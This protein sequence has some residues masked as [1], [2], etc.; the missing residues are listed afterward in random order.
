MKVVVTGGTGFLGWHLV[1]RLLRDGHDVTFTGRQLKASAPLGSCFAKVNLTDKQG[2]NKVMQAAEW[3]FHSA[4]LS[5]PWGDKQDFFEANVMG[6]Q[7]VVD[8]C[9]VNNVQRLIHVSTPSLYVNGQDCMMVKEDDPL[10]KQAINLY[11]HSKR[12]AEDIIKR[13]STKLAVI[14][15]RPRAIFGPGDNAIFPRFIAALQAGRLPIIG[16]GDNVADL[17]YVDNV[18]D[19]L[20]LCAQA[21]SKHLG[22]VY[23]ISNG[24]PVR[25]WDVIGH[26]ARALALPEPRHK[27]PYRLVYTLAASL[28]A[29]H[30]L[31]LPHKEPRLTRYG[32]TVLGK[33]MTL[34]IGAAQRDLGYEPKVS[35]EDGLEQVIAAYQ[36]G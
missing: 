27:L 7:Y 34:D 16:S 10:P 31:F 36:Q 5:S 30:K 17:S 25:L 19:A 2:L 15:I 21:D 24:E 23:N 6:T 9:L 1:M 32:V 11:A 4:A 33:S 12:L 13:A 35:M 8:A 14:S 28:E 29:T 18:V 26:L 22:K 3:V 20:L